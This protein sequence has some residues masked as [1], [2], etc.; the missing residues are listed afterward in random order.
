MK[1]MFYEPHCICICNTHTTNHL[2]HLFFFYQ[3]HVMSVKCKKA[4]I[5][6]NMSR[7][8]YSHYVITQFKHVRGTYLFKGHTF[9]TKL[10]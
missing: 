4:V 9:Q 7:F 5:C 1:I 8:S 6:T 2:H 3:M 10:L